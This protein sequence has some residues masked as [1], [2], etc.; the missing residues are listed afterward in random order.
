MHFLV[1]CVYADGVNVENFRIVQAPSRLAVAAHIVEH[2]DLWNTFLHDA[3]LYEPIVRG[4]MPYYVDA[5]RVTPEEALRLIDCSSVDGENR[6][7]MSIQ[8]IIEIISLPEEQP[9]AMHIVGTGAF[10]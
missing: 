4:N 2:S 6:A 9:N 7:R 8:Q 10:S 1:A 5:R 3:Q